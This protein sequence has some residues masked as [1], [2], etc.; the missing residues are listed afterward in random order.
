MTEAT[1]D[2][3]LPYAERIAKLLRKAEATD[4][5]QEAESYTSKAQE[6]MVTW[7]IS[8]E[9]LNRAQGK[10][11]QDKIEQQLFRYT[12]IYQAVLMDIGWALIRRNHCKGVYHKDT[13]NKP[14][15][16]IITVTGFRSDIDR[17][18]M[19]DSSLQIQCQSAMTAWWKESDRSYLSKMQA[20]K[21]KREFIASF[22]SGLSA[23]LAEAERA[24]K[25][26]AVKAEAERRRQE[27][28]TAGK[29]VAAIEA[30][31][32]SSVELVLRSKDEQVKDWF[33]NRYGKSLRTVKRR[34]ESGGWSAR[35]AGYTAG[36]NANTGDTAIGGR[37][38]LGS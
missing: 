18:V 4:N 8:E 28:D 13:W 22:A 27:A 17:L 24:G 29:S 6:L 38:S 34:Y 32:S 10:Q 16:H 2:Q 30:E 3:K 9:L 12:G 1:V 35:E 21:M 33:D 7:G 37:R 25:V 26:A 5:V 14:T 20:F 19:L 36:R 11:A 23:R 15:A 31:V